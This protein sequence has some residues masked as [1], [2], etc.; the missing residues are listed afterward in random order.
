MS[1][2]T[3]LV[4]LLSAML[5]LG[6]LTA[7]AQPPDTRLVPGQLAPVLEG[8]GDLHHEIT[9][10]SVRAQEF[11]DQGLRLVYAFNHA[12]AIRAFREAARLDPRC[13][14]A[15]WGHALALGPNINDPMPFEREVEAAKVIRQALKLKG[16]VS[17]SEGA[18]IDALAR[19]YS[20]RRTRDRAALDRAY[21]DAMA[22]LAEREAADLDAASL[23]AESLLDLSPWD[24]WNKDGSPRYP[25]VPKVVSV[26]EGVL[27]RKPD[28]PGALHYYIHAV[29]AS[30]EPERGLGAADRL[31]PLLPTA[32]HL[33]HMPAHI[34][35]RTGRYADA[36]EANVR[37]VSADESYIAQCRAQGLYPAIY[38]PHNVH[39]LWAAATFQGRSAVAIDAARKLSQTVGHEGA[40]GPTPGQDW[41]VTPLY[42]LV[43]FGRWDEILAEPS[44]WEKAYGRAIWHYARGLAFAAKG[45]LDEGAEELAKLQ[46]AR[47]DPG[48][49]DEM[50]GFDPAASVLEV[51]VGTLA[52]ELAWRRGQKDEAVHSLREA[53]AAQDRLRYNE[54]PE[55]HHPVR[56]V[57][58]A[59]LL[60]AGR[61]GEAEEAYRQDL[62]ENKENG[63]SLFGLLQSLR[64]QGKN[65]EASE[66]EIRFR[67][68]WAQADVVLT[69][70]RF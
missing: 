16:R 29:E 1:L 21:A 39:F 8:L 54:P 11:F 59:V 35:I 68:A 65:Q 10:S 48:L 36:A 9:T 32:G 60:D 44:R 62:R 26:L 22:A 63:W 51:P 14:M 17:A 42:A 55:W 56:Q 15:Y 58:G 38:Y 6:S 13:A 4:P 7:T 31:G 5:S 57:L 40:C 64:G 46:A 28:H 52:A 47:I 43:R 70:S 20:S 49:K 61:L 25:H 41:S 18:Y 50:L 37:A 24:Y 66:V 23:Y 33:V 67:R 34:Y 19:R 69:S 2:R 27:A 45:R 12:E 30:Q 53:V 3:P